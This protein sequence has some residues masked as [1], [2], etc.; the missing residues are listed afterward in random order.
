MTKYDLT[1]QNLQFMFVYGSLHAHQAA[2][3][4]S[5]TAHGRDDVTL[6]M[7]TLRYV[8]LRSVTVLRVRVKSGRRFA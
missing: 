2:K 4:D 1:S 3:R 5:K 7:V 6:R 8:L